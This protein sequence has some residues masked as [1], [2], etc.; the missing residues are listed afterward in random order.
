MVTV[1]DLKYV[2]FPSYIGST[3]KSLAIR[4]YIKN[5][6]RRS[7]ACICISHFTHNRLIQRFGDKPHGECK[8]IYH[9]TD[10]KSSVHKE[11]EA[12]SSSFLLFVGE[13]R[14]HKKY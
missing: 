3:I 5:S 8:T 12:S 2:D 6:Y 11:V 13:N 7:T 9:G 1:H 10:D 14:P 4:L